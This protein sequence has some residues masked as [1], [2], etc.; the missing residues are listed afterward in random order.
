[1]CLRLL[2]L[3]GLVY[4]WLAGW[5]LGSHVHRPHLHPVLAESARVAA[6]SCQ[7]VADDTPRYPFLLAHLLT[8]TSATD[9]VSDGYTCDQP[10]A[11]A[12]VSDLLSDAPGHDEGH[13]MAQQHT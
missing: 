9:E 11:A 8:L 5:T 2:S 13:Q 3:H 1:M 4:R 7:A 6:P 12:R 10:A